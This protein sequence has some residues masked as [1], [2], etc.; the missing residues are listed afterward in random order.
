[1]PE[2][3]TAIAKVEAYLNIRPSPPSPP[4]SPPIDAPEE[5]RVG[6][7]RALFFERLAGGVR[8]LCAHRM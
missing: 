3:K 2:I 4:A 7:A 1:M 6:A 8:H 5:L